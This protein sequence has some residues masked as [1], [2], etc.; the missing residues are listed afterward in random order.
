MTDQLALYPCP[1]D[2][3]AGEEPDDAR[4]C[5]RN[6]PSKNGAV[7]H[8]VNSDDDHHNRL[9]N[10]SEAGDNLMELSVSTA[11][12]TPSPDMED[13]EVRDEPP[14]A[15]G[16]GTATE[17]VF[18]PEI[19]P[20]DDAGADPGS[21]DGGTEACPNCGADLDMTEQEIRD[22]REEHGE[23][24]CDSCGFEVVPE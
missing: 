8:A 13:A 16:G 10:K 6:F 4:T 12:D 21:D 22:F 2:M 7:M 17:D 20:A 11:A 5:G 3:A 15:D 1:A 23:A 24:Y 14:A 19:P 9:A 18:D